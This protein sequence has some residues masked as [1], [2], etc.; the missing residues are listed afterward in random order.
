MSVRKVPIPRFS[1]IDLLRNDTILSMRLIFNNLTTY[2]QNPGSD[3]KSM[4]LWPVA[5]RPANPSFAQITKSAQIGGSR[6]KK[7]CVSFS[8][9]SHSWML[10]YW[11]VW[12]LV[13]QWILGWRNEKTINGRTRTMRTRDEREKDVM[14]FSRGSEKSYLIKPNWS[15]SNN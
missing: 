2:L 14:I 9:E 11:I 6:P 1:Q 3:M 12:S 15:R 10:R 7:G 5:S 8:T 13:F 4:C